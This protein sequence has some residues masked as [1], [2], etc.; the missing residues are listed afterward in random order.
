MR[1]KSRGRNEF[2]DE[3][4]R[5]CYIFKDLVA[6][7]AWLRREITQQHSLI[8]RCSRKTDDYHQ[9]ESDYKAW[10]HRV[11]PS[12]IISSE[13]PNA[14]CDKSADNSSNCTLLIGALPIETKDNG[15]PEDCAGCTKVEHLEHHNGAVSVNERKCG[16]DDCNQNNAHTNHEEALLVVVFIFSEGSDDQVVAKGSSSS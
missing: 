9:D 12:G 1:S 16:S 8:G 2:R 4:P 14:V 13:E 6:L 10:E 3:Q 11:Q 7:L 15:N 5:L